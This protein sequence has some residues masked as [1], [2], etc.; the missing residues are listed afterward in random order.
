M[1]FKEKM[2]GAYFKIKAKLIVGAI[3]M[4]MI[5]FAACSPLSIS[6]VDGFTIESSENQ[7]MS[8]SYNWEAFYESLANNISSPFKA[9]QTCFSRKY[10]P[11]F[12]KSVSIVVLI[13]FFTALIGF[14]KAIPKHEYDDIEHGSSKWSEGGEQYAILS[15]K[16]G[17]ILAKK[18]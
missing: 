14:Y 5:V 4:L 6:I 8:D 13:Y 3:L 15:N 16:K 9:F 18:N 11:M 7:V 2:R 12:S 10:F 1:N 17:I